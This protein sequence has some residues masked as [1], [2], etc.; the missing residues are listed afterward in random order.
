MGRSWGFWVPLALLGF[1]E[2]ILAAVRL[3][4]GAGSAAGEFVNL[5]AVPMDRVH[6]DYFD[7]AIGGEQFLSQDPLPA[8]T[9]TSA[10]GWPIALALVVAIVL[11]GY[12]RAGTRPKT[13][14]FALALAGGVL[15][16]PVLDLAAYAQFDLDADARGPALAAVGLVVLGG[17]RAQSPGPR[18][19]RGL[20]GGGDA[21]T[22]RRG[23]GFVG[24][25][26]ARGGVSGGRRTREGP[27]AACRRERVRPGRGQWGREHRVLLVRTRSV[28][29]R[30][31][32]TRPARRRARRRTGGER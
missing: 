6:V 29:A 14:R 16:V 13:G 21:A 15:A 11:V 5:S 8:P 25:G 2:L 24:S 7:T 3:A 27:F 23:G 26:A 30:F 10:L 22:G 18:G 9:S 20:R 31:A 4:A 32:R 28:R 1:A 17:V 12:A 19:H